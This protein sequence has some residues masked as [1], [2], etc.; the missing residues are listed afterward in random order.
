MKG[1]AEQICIDRYESSLSLIYHFAPVCCG[2]AVHQNHGNTW[3]LVKKKTNKTN[4]KNKK[5]KKNKQKKKKKKQIKHFF[6]F[7]PSKLSKI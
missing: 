2:N 3:E 7:F 5:Q 1:N 6:F 4:K